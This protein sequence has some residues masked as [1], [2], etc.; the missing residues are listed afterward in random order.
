MEIVKKNLISIICGVV[1][2][3]AL[4]VALVM[5]PSRQTELQKELDA[6][7]STYD[8]LSTLL[9]KDRKLPVVDPESTDQQPLPVFPSEGIIAQGTQIMKQVEKESASMRDAAVAM[10]R[11]EL[12]VPG[13]L[14]DVNLGAAYQFRDAYRRA[15]PVAV[16]ANGQPIQPGTN[17]PNAGNPTTQ[18]TFAKALDAGMPPPAQEIT[19]KQQELA[20]KIRRENT[21]IGGQGGQVINQPQVDQMVK[22]QTSDLPKQLMTDVAKSSRIYIS[23]D[24]FEVNPQIAQATGAPD[25]VTIYLAQLDYWIQQDVVKAIAGIN[26]GSKSI[27][28]SPVKHL[29][30][31][32]ADSNGVPIPVFPPG[33]TAANDDPDGQLKKDNTVSPTGRVCNGMYDVYHFTVKADVEAA[34]LADFLRGLGKDQFITPIGVDVHAV[35]NA[36]ALAQGYIYGDTPVVNVTAHCEVLYLRQWDA[37]FMPAQVKTKFGIPTTGQPGAPG[38]QQ[39]SATLA[40]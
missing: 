39:A 21:L 4:I 13:C 36:T 5:V 11:H 40:P 8:Q 15:L 7:K 37:P 20:D 2:L 10:N 19:Q 31:I 38:A 32:R 3:A 29:I 22:D 18:S 30:S 34:K 33:A 14:P 9:H 28:D 16:G 24:T 25:V 6:R 35:D 12:L 1:A 26:A 23:P 17:N 27:A